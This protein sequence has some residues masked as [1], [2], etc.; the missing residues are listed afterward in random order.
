MLKVSHI[1]TIIAFALLLMSCSKQ[2]IE[3][4]YINQ[5]TAIDKFIEQ[6]YKDSTVVTKGGARRIIMNKGFVL[7]T[8]GNATYPKD[9]LEY[10][11]NIKLFYAA[12]IFGNSGPT[13]IVATNVK[14][15]AEKSGLELTEPDFEMLDITYG[16]ES[17]VEGLNSG[18]YG[19]REN[20]YSHIIFSSKYGFKNEFVAHIPKLSSLF[21]EVWIMNVNKKK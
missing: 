14:E 8:Y 12:Y 9:S 17:F 6:K 18:I 13:T 20:E 4:I 15:I 10:G 3:L 21:Y 2:D 5:E 11:D 19:V 16:E 1:I 7:D